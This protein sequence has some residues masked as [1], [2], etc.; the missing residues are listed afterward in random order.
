MNISN[1]TNKEII[2]SICIPTYNQPDKVKRFFESIISQLNSEINSQ[3]EIVVRDD[4]SN[5]ETKKIIED[6]SK[7]ISVP[8]KYFHGKKEGVDVAIIFLTQEAKGD[9]VWW[10]GDDVLADG[11]IARVIKLVK[12]F[13]E[14]SFI[15]VNSCD[16]NNRNDTAFELEGDKF[17]D[18]RNQLM[19]KNIGMLGFISATIFKKEKALS[20]IENS[21]KYINS[22]F[23][24]LY[25]ILHVLSQDG[26]FYFLNNPYVLADPK[27]QG[28]PRWYDAFQVFGINLYKVVCEFKDKFDNQSI[29]KAL[30]DN[31]GKVWRAVLVERALGFTEGFGSKNP[32]LKQMFKYYWNFPE[33]WLA[34]PFLII[35]RFILRFLY[36]FYKFLR[37]YARGI[38]NK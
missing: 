23:V 6:Y 30:A 31:F 25:L 10:F 29:R 5:L 17:F 1:N 8:I 9:Y 11:A 37:F 36:K 38:L 15:W 24:S 2:L 16:I 32:K 34:L 18:N 7:K 28:K 3:I 13:P 4:S 14:I 22:A 19:E 33:F 35:P 20:G 27:F 21:K 26:R 12:D